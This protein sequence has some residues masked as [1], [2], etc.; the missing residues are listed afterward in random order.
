[1]ERPKV[2]NAIIAF[3]K[4][5]NSNHQ[6]SSKVSNVLGKLLCTEWDDDELFECYKG[7][8]RAKNSWLTR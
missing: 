2:A 4:A 3:A 8:K 1:M 5:V 7:L 6:L